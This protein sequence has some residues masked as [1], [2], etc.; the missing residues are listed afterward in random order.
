MRTNRRERGATLALVAVCLLALLA[1]AALAIDLGLLYVARSE[2]QRA[3]D[4]AALAGAEVFITSGCTST[5]GCV[6]GGSQEPPA[7]QQ[8]EAVGGED[9]IDGTAASIQDS[10]ISFSYPTPEE[11][12]ITVT[13]QRTQ[14]R[15]DAVPTIFAKVFGASSADVSVTAMAEAYNPTGGG[16]T[17]AVNCVAPFLVPN[18]DPAHLSPSTNP[19]CDGGAGDAGYFIN[20]NTGQIQNPQLQPTGAIGEEWQLH[21]NTAP[22]QW[23][24]VAF[25]GSQSAAN[26][27][28]W[29]AQCTP[30]VIACNSTI[31]TMNGTKVGPTTQGVDDRIHASNQGPNNGQDTANVATGPP[32]QITGGANNP[33]PALIG[34][35]YYGPSDSVVTVPVYDGHQLN[36]GG[37]I[38]TVVGFMQLFI[39]WANHQSNTDLVDS[40]VLQVTPCNSGGGTPGAGPVTPDI[41]STGGSPIPIRLIHP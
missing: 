11:P 31:Q 26:E 40:Y 27:R 13:V 9:Y 41:V 34:Q 2:A 36:P 1:V 25:G 21:T 15:G 6:A 39:N 24:L 10:D 29:I 17:I 33:I 22:S 32:F 8:A 14:A 16:A 20:P 23:Y 35:I 28:A 37:D 18:C 5:G 7:R 12:Q 38:V 3:A 4:A 30:M 19:V